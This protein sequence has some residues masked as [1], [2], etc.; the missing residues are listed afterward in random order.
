MAQKN[1]FGD[2][3]IKSKTKV[4]WFLFSDSVDTW[5]HVGS[6]AVRRGPAPFPGQ[7]S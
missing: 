7:K 6:G 3:R 4:I 2:F 5:P 1:M